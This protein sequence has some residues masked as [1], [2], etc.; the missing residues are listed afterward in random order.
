MQGTRGEGQRGERV[1]EVLETPT[2]VRDWFLRPPYPGA[3]LAVVLLLLLVAGSIMLG[4]SHGTPPDPP[5]VAFSPSV[6]TPQQTGEQPSVEVQPAPE[7]APVVS[8]RPIPGAEAKGNTPANAPQG[9]V[10]LNQP[11]IISPHAPTAPATR[12]AQPGLLP[13]APEITPG[14]TET[15]AEPTPADTPKAE[16]PPVEIPAPEPARPEP[17]RPEPA[18]PEPSREEEPRPRPRRRAAP[19]VQVTRPTGRM[20]VFFDADSSTFDRHDE[21]MPLRVQVYVDGRKRLESSDPEKREFDLGDLPEGEHEVVVVPFVGRNQPEPRRFR[22]DIGAEA[23]NR[24][25]AVLR[26]EDGFSK[27]SKFRARD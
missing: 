5:E 13:G 16:T 11:G 20:T 25:K 14:P 4:R 6:V 24:F 23:D 7:D 17:V 21:R 22:V 3:I 9:N 26:R 8:I 19:P 1:E 27:I 10:P 12:P 15:P 2:P 18:R